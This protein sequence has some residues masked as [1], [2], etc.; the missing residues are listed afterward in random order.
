MVSKDGF[1]VYVFLRG[2]PQL[3]VGMVEKRQRE[4]RVFS[5]KKRIL[6][7][8]QIG[9]YYTNNRNLQIFHFPDID[10]TS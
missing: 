1:T 5:K 7:I 6:I 9:A 8:E 10:V 3:K 2:G 4:R